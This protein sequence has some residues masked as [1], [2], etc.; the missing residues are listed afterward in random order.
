MNRIGTVLWCALYVFA[1]SAQAQV[2]DSSVSDVCIYPVETPPKFLVAD[3]DLMAYVRTEIRKWK[4]EIS[5]TA[6]GR[7]YIRFTITREGD[8]ADVAILREI[9]RLPVEMKTRSVQLIKNLAVRNP[10]NFRGK[11]VSMRLVVPFVF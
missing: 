8:I 5:D 1:I 10:G 4:H 3:D 9:G 7:L 6:S 2:A 11:P